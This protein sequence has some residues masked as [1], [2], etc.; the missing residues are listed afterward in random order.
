VAV[1]LRL[2][3][4]FTDAEIAEQ[5]ARR[6][7]SNPE[8][9][10]TIAAEVADGHVTLRGEIESTYQ[11]YDAIEYRGFT[12]FLAFREHVPEPVGEV[13]FCYRGDARS[14]MADSYL[15]GGA[16]LG[17][18]G[19]IASPRSLWPR[20]EIVD[21]ARSIARDTVQARRR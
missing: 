21:L 7:S 19:R 4:K 14:N 16:K 18:D 17:M 6:R 1:Q 11:M 15:T 3:G 8:I 13:V 5:I 9:P 12:D 2:P 20:D 10:A